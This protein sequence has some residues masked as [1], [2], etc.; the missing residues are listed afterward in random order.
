MAHDV[1]TPAKSHIEYEYARRRSANEMR[2]QVTTFAIMI[3][4]TLI[5][6]TAVYAGFSIN[7]VVPIILLLAAIQVVLQL[8]YFMHMSHKGHEAASLFLYSGALIAG[9]TILTFITI[10]WI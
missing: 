7:F 1:Q 4:L 5:A 8:Y 6:F 10:V 9:I 3:F 2:G